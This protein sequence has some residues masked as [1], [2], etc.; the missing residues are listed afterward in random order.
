MGM[1]TKRA[2]LESTLPC[3]GDS[4]MNKGL[5]GNAREAG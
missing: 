3:E 4:F 1:K 2:L 5:I